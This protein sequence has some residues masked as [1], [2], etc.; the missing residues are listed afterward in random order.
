MAIKV[1]PN[2]PGIDL[3]GLDENDKW[4][5]IYGKNILAEAAH[6]NKLTVDNLFRSCRMTLTYDT[7]IIPA[8]TWTIFPLA[9]SA[10]ENWTK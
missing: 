7:L 5:N 2:R 6:I 4:E 8:E 10:G 3:G 1:S 9:Y